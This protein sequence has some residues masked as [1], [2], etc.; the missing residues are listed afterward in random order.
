[1]TNKTEIE[2][3]SL[4]E[5]YVTVPN[6]F[7]RGSL[8]SNAK[9][10]MIM[11]K[12]HSE[13]WV[14]NK[15]QIGK[16]LEWGEGK[17]TKHIKELEDANHLH[18]RQPVSESGAII[19][20]PWIWQLSYQGKAGRSEKSAPPK[21]RGAET[22]RVGKSPPIRRKNIKKP[23]S[24]NNPPSPFDKSLGSFHYMTEGEKYPIPDEFYP[25]RDIKDYALIDLR[26]YPQEYRDIIVNFSEYWRDRSKNKNGKKTPRGWKACLRTW[27][28]KEAVSLK[29][30]W[31]EQ[32]FDYRTKEEGGAAAV[33]DDIQ[34][35]APEYWELH[36]RRY[37]DQGD[38][39]AVGPKPDEADCV[40]PDEILQKYGFP[41]NNESQG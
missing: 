27:L 41:I 15:K 23:N 34:E 2:V 20:G 29:A 16:S 10:L 9:I 31:R 6:S 8:S 32:P 5:P 7:V 38:W 21:I 40:A 3:E 28:N 39:T 30:K 17:L 4:D 26:I 12:S 11:L 13:N 24:K 22:P 33:P 14:F 19:P 1:M 36:V 37:S 35:Y 18:R 25:G